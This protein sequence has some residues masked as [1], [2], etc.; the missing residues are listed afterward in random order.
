M[1]HSGIARK[2]AT[3]LLTVAA[4]VLIALSGWQLWPAKSGKSQ[5]V[6]SAPAG[7]ET[8]DGAERQIVFV[9]ET[10]PS[11]P[12]KVAVIVPNATRLAPDSSEHLLPEEEAQE[13]SVR[14]DG[15]LIYYYWLLDRKPSVHKPAPPIDWPETTT[16]HPNRKLVF[17]LGSEAM[18]QR[19]DVL[20]YDEL[21]PG[22][23][24]NEETAHL[25]SCLSGVVKGEA[26]CDVGRRRDPES[27][28]WMIEVPVSSCS[29]ECY[30]AIY[31]NWSLP[32]DA[33]DRD[34]VR[35]P[36]YAASWI[37]ALD[38]AE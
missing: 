7:W 24:P 29:G 12:P 16:V 18:P 2:A 34:G 4:V 10:A 15:K 11:V 6:R 22:N 36:E 37:F 19:L 32:K 26:E 1:R 28:K 30:V 21:G 9:V 35:I 13:K 17:D 27:G 5:Q 38:V 31:A 8:T 3:V 20:L 14:H 23:V 33:V 25:L